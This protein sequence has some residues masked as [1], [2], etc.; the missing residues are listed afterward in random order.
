MPL[1]ILLRLI[2]INWILVFHGLDELVLKTHLFR[3][4]RYLAFFSPNFWIRKDRGP[5]GVRIRRAFEDLGPIFVKFGQALSTRRDLLPLDVADELAKLQDNVPAF[6]GAEARRII[7]RE[8]GKPIAQCFAEFDEKPLASASIAQVHAARLPGGEEVV[9]K[10]LR[11]GV[12]KRIREDIGLLYELAR[13]AR[14]FWADGKR[15]RPVEVV[16]EFEKTIVDELDLVREGANASALRRNFEHSSILY[17]PLVH[18]D[19]TREKVLVM[20]RIY[21]IPIGDVQALRDEGVNFKLLAE[22]GVEI[23]FTQVLRDNFFHADMHPGNIFAKAD[24]SYIAVD[25]GIVGSLS[26]A[27]QHYLAYNLLAFFHRDYRRVA[28][29]HIESGWVPAETRVEELESGIR[30]VCE[31]IFEKPISQ[32]SYGHLLLRLF[33]AARRFNAEIQPQLVLFQKTLLNIEGLGRELYPD[34][35][36]WQTAKPYLEK[37]F[38]QQVGP[39]AA[40]KKVRKL[41]PEWGEQIPEIPALFHRVLQN[42]AKR[43]SDLSWKDHELGEI[44]KQLARNNKRTVG[45]ISGAALLISAAILTGLS[46][47][48]TQSAESVPALASGFFALGFLLIALSF[49]D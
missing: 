19:W 16:A 8:L 26:L 35:D 47:S 31:P 38:A 6:S 36:L 39:K 5:R 49:R 23:F 18:W 37:W 48:L 21:G 43:G 32:I 2:R 15:L 24:A 17:I 40:F 46:G 7:E 44:K 10:V 13:L 9:V 12:E 45:A 3:P 27:D 20:E 11:P 33:Q 14:R 30:A 29:L 34:L 25:F 22:R 41:L 1:K 42:S 28:E 4:L